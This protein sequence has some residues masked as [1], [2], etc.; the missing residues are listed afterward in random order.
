MLIFAA[1][2]QERQASG[3]DP[4]QWVERARARSRSQP[5]D[6]AV[7]DAVGRMLSRQ[8]M[9]RRMSAALDKQIE[10]DDEF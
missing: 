10:H 9:H 8:R 1:I 2:E 4:H 7:R 3:I 5:S 6:P